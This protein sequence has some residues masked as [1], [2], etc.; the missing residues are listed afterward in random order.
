MRSVAI[1]MEEGMNKKSIIRSDMAPAENYTNYGI[2]FDKTKS[3]NR[4]CN[5]FQ[6]INVGM[7]EKTIIRE[8][9]NRHK[10]IHPTEKPIRLIERLLALVANPGEV[11]VDPFAGSFVTAKAC[12]N[13]GLNYILWEIDKEFYQTG[14]ESLINYEKIKNLNASHGDLFNA[15]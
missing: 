1:S 7:N 5:A 15:I 9:G 10:S 12:I 13:L 11:V 3:G 2:T 6:S 4:A 8:T 14:M